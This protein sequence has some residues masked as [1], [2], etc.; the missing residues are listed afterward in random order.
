MLV[1]GVLGF[2]SQV[3]VVCLVLP[4]TFF[5]IRRKWRLAV[6]RK[7]DI[8][9]LLIL[10][11]EEAARAELE[12]SVGYVSV[13]AVA[14]DYQCAVCYCPTTTRCA[15]CKAVRYWYVVLNSFNLYDLNC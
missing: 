5:V 6:A 1:T 15:R 8:K 7:E 10:A 12:A 11:S 2:P 3:L 9:R 14:R 4:V 13:A